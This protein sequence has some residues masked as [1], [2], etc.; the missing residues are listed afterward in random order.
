MTQNAFLLWYDSEF[1]KRFMVMVIHEL[2]F[3]ALHCE[4]EFSLSQIQGLKFAIERLTASKF[5]SGTEGIP[6]I[7]SNVP[8]NDAANL[9]A[10]GDFYKGLNREKQKT[11]ISE[12][13]MA[14]VV[15]AG[16]IYSY[17][18][19]RGYYKAVAAGKEQSAVAAGLSLFSLSPAHPE[20]EA[21]SS[22]AFKMRG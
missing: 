10:L 3:T 19:G 17:Q 22:A 9:L 8:E 18:E 1:S 15:Q 13:V 16:A 11:L 20:Q 4:I 21:R 5:I 6:L 7:N 12:L 2:F 14:V